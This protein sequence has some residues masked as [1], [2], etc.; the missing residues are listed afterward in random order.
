MQSDKQLGAVITRD[1]KHIAFYSRKLNRAQQRYTTGEQE[2]LSIVESL[3][4]FCN[5]LS[6]YK[7]I[8]HTDHKILTCKKHL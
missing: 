3:R 5:I 7:I 8:V 1:E 4:E 6:G 2:S